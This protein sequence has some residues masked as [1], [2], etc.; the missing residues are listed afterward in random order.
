MNQY[1]LPKSGWDFFDVSRAYGLGIVVHTLSEEATVSDVGGFYLVE[2]S[3]NVNFSRIDEINKWLPEDDNAW[4]QTF[5]TIGE[6]L[7]RRKK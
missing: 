5:L 1:F 7:E 4:N 3:K 2:S 6:K